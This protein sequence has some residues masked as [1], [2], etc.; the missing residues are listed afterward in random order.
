MLVILA[1]FLSPAQTEAE[2]G[3]AVGDA[4]ARVEHDY[5]GVAKCKSCHGKELMGDQVSAW[6]SG[7]H[8][9][10]WLVLQS[11]EALRVAEE[12]GLEMPPSEAPECLVCHV[13]AFGV[14]PER[15]SKPLDERDGVQCESCHGPGRHYRK[16]KIMADLDRAK[17]NGLWIPDAQSGV[18]ERCHNE[19]SPTFRTDR[20]MRADGAT[21]A[22]DYQ[23]A[24][25]EVDH[26]IP[27]HVKG[28]YLELDEARKKA[29]KAQ[30]G[31]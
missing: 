2:S 27:E 8:R 4:S 19:Q 23:L 22:F 28:Q 11:P 21:F 9:S 31:D 17:A 20:F 25:V 15:I 26:P 7:P 16:K 5:V 18:C 3:M 1:G 24:V 6:K 14:P 10:G 29:E 30:R 13:T 12:E